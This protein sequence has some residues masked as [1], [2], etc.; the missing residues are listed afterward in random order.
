MNNITFNVNSSPSTINNSMQKLFS[1]SSTTTGVKYHNRFD[2]VDVSDKLNLKDSYDNSI[3]ISS[4]C[5]KSSLLGQFDE[6]NNNDMIV[7]LLALKEILI[8]KNIITK[9][10][11]SCKYAKVDN[12]IQQFLNAKKIFAELEK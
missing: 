7:S 6:L 5:M 12:D 3:E 2:S 10:E 9:E 8:D 11:W 4:E 1:N